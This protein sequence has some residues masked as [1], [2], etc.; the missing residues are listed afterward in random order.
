MRPLATW[1]ATQDAEAA[2][3]STLDVDDRA[4]TA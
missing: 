3:P 2:Q 1:A 4:P